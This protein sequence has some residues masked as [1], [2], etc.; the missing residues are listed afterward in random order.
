MRKIKMCPLKVFGNESSTLVN[1]P[2]DAI[3]WPKVYNNKTTWWPTMLKL[4]TL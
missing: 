1:Q 3:F 2:L 4:S